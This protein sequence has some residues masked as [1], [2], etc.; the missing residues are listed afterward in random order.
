MAEEERMSVEMKGRK[1]ARSLEIRMAEMG[2][3]VVENLRI[4]T[5]GNVTEMLRKRLDLDFLHGNNFPQ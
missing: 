5:H 1:R 2:R 4:I 3:R